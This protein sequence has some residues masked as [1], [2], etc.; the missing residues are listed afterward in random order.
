MIISVEKF[1]ELFD[2]TT[3]DRFTFHLRYNIQTYIDLYSYF[4]KNNLQNIINYYQDSQANPDVESFYYLDRLLQE[5]TKIDNLIKSNKN[6]FSRVDDWELLDFL[7]DIR[8]NLETIKQS[9][10]WTRSSKSQQIWRGNVIQ[11]PYT[12]N[13]GETLESVS[14]KVY[15][16]FDSQNDWMRIGI[17]N[18]LLE[19]DYG[20]NT[21]NTILVNKKVL[22]SPNFFARSI[23]DNLVNEKLY[24]LDFDRKIQFVDNDLKILT[25][26]DTVVQAVQILIQLIRGDIPEFPNMGVDSSVTVGGSVGA[27]LFSSI[28]RQLEDT[29]DTDDS[30]RNFQVTSISYQNGDLVI[31]Y[32]VDTLYNLTY[33]SKATL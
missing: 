1:D 2:D 11:T 25:Y 20:A 24:G 21:S 5:A 22:S 28:I 16:S 33:N 12:M 7:E 18:N 30:V 15:G 23:V 10:K 6:S 29:F 13:D 17:E 3:I 27:I 14:E 8:S 32:S 26:R 9:P 19:S 4:V 31:E